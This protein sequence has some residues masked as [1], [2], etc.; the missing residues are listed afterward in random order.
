VPKSGKFVVHF[1]GL[2]YETPNLY[3]NVKFDHQDTLLHKLLYA[4]FAW[5]LC[6]IVKHHELPDGLFNFGEDDADDDID[7]DIDADK[8]D[9][10]SKKR[11]LDEGNEDEKGSGN[12][13]PNNSS[14]SDPNLGGPSRTLQATGGPVAGQDHCGSETL[15]DEGSQ[16]SIDSEEHRKACRTFPDLYSGQRP[17][18][19]DE[20]EEMVWYPG[21]KAIEK[22]K[23]E[24]LRS[25]PQIQARVGPFLPDNYDDDEPDKLNPFIDS[26]KRE[27]WF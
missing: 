3:H 4:R 24:Y 8:K 5:A 11:K 7:D 9:S 16:L 1:L 19:P 18:R 13:N 15:S 14:R 10:S 6:T 21:M 17:P 22:R 25:H 20:W 23:Q 2:A 26:T 27:F 12:P